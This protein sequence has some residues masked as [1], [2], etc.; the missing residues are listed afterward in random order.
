MQRPTTHPRREGEGEKFHGV[1]G[2]T[3]T[4]PPPPPPP[5]AEAAQRYARRGRRRRAREG[6]GQNENVKT[7]QNEANDATHL[8]G[9]VARPLG[10]RASASKL[11]DVVPGPGESER[12]QGWAGGTGDASRDRADRGPSSSL[13]VGGGRRQV[14]NCVAALTARAGWRRCES[15]GGRGGGRERGRRA[16]RESGGRGSIRRPWPEGGF[17]VL[18]PVAG[19]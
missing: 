12:G 6:S 15:H 1:T 10:R 18:G 8:H 7:Q 11:L 9:L 2:P 4:P 5:P 17:K 14:G 3:T 13:C 19:L 16:G